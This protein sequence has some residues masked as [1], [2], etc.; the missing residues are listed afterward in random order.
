MVN[1]KN[2]EEVKQH[3]KEDHIKNKERDNRQ[4]REYSKNHK[5]DIKKYYQK[6]KEKVKQSVYK[7]R[8]ENHQ[9]WMDSKYQERKNYRKKYPQRLKATRLV[10]RILKKMPLGVL[11]QDCN[12]LA[13]VRHHE[14]YD[15][16]LE[17]VYLCTLCHQKRHRNRNQ[18]L[19]MA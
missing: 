17:V 11:C 18:I 8:E 9:K 7:W 19:L 16:P 15:K 14:D 5:E 2:K 12:T 13:K 4:S 6:N 3:R 1:W 10:A